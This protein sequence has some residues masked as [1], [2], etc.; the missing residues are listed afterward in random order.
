[1]KQFYLN[2]PLGA[3]TFRL[4]RPL[5][6]RL[7]RVLRLKKG[8]T[9]GLFNGRD[10]LWRATLTDPSEGLVALEEQVK[11]QPQPSETHLFLALAK[12]D[13][14]DRAV[15]FATELGASHIHPVTTEFSVPDKLKTERLETI[16]TEAAE[17]CERLT[18]PEM[19]AAKDLQQAI[20]G[21]SGRIFWADESPKDDPF[22][23][24]Q[25]AGAAGVLIGPEGGFS[26]KERT[27][28]RQQSHIIP[29]G[30][31][32]NILRV[33]TA[34]CAGLTLLSGQREF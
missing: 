13:A 34:V 25:N 5:A 32:Q 27:W 6:R 31:G 9:I 2:S 33:D 18:L 7:H 16:I 21:F 12:R 23:G 3:G 29:V 8:Q 17:Q 11:A 4:P 10:G 30:L 26:D 28:L 1:M 24:W 19:S 14:F 20:A 22:Q 15:R